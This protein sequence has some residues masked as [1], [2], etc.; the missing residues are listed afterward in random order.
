M[1][2]ACVAGLFVGVVCCGSMGWLLWFTRP[3]RKA[4]N[5]FVLG[6]LCVVFTA[7]AIG[8]LLLLSQLDKT[9]GIAPLST[10]YYPGLYSYV[11][12]VVS[13]AIIAIRAESRWRKSIGL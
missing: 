11:V 3:Y 7:T 5:L 12:G 13:V 1:L 9:L 2:I 4:R 6:L 8:S 10:F